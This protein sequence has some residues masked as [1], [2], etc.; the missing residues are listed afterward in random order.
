LQTVKAFLPSM[1]EHN[2]GHIV[3]IASMAGYVGVA[4]LVDYCSSKAAA[5]GFDE[6]LRLELETK[7]IK[8]V[9]TSLICPFFIR[10]TGMFDDVNSRYGDTSLPY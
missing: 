7:G 10:S 5:C 3:T 1:I 2:D 6:S 9:R 4:K 8:G